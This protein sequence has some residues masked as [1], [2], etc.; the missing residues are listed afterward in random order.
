MTTEDPK[1]SQDDLK[2]SVLFIPAKTKKHLH[3]WIQVF[4][5][6]DIPDCIVDPESNSSPMDMLWEV[7]SKALLND[8]PTFDRVLYFASRDSF[9]TLGAAI[10]EVLAVVH[11]NRSVAHMAAIESQSKKSQQ[12]VK[13]FL[14]MPFLREY[15]VGDNQEI[16]WIVRYENNETK[17]NIS[18]KIFLS[19]TEN[20][21]NQHTEFRHFIRIVICTMAGANS[22]HVPLFIID[23]I[24]T[25]RDPRAYEEAQMIPAPYGGN[26]PITLLTSTRKSSF[27]LVQKEVDNATESG[28]HLRHWN[29][30]DVTEACPSERHMPELPRLPVYVNDDTLTSLEEADFQALNVDE[31]IKFGK[32][33]AYAGCMTNC[34]LFA[35]CKGRLAT[36]QTSKSKLLKPISHTINSFKKVSLSTA[37][38]QLLCR[39]PSTE[40]LVYPNFDKEIHMLTASEMAE[41]ITGAPHPEDL[42]KEQLIF[43]MR[44]WKLQFYSGMDFG[45]T[46]QFAVTTGAVDGNRAF[47]IDQIS[48]AELEDMQKVAV[49]K[50]HLWALKPTIFADPESPQSIKTLRRAGFSMRDWNK[51]PGSLIAGIDIV[52]TK[53]RPSIGGEPQIYLLKGDPGCELLAKR[54]A[55]YHWKKD[56]AGRTTDVP[57]DFEDDECDGIR[58]FIMNVF[59][60]KTGV[61]ASKDVKISSQSAPTRENWFK[62][63]LSEHGVVSGGGIVGETKGKSGNFKF[64][65][66]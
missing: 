61:K 11:L 14:G 20:E 44:Q 17:A 6:L 38:A 2:R 7:Y 10:L 25:V 21:K 31:Q 26:M 50:K 33:E 23:E 62:K 5:G 45:Y 53:F 27:G 29:I 48:E 52:R 36:E 37:R 16:T 65:M 30:I 28:L 64:D 3:R 13:K 56:A 46:H 15:V 24:D 60:G 19:L 12:Y 49:C 39:K 59:A 51:G 32:Y 9:K 66:S 41:K 42:T 43:I 57:D 47:I 55:A 34:K 8:D 1:P 22:E 63:V 35:V 4:L 18:E 58:Y 54:L 40:G